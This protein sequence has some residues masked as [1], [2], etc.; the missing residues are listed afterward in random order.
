MIKIL[1]YTQNP[2]TYMGKIAGI[3]YNSDTE[4]QD[5]NYKRGLKNIEHNHGRVFEYVDVTL[6]IS[7]YSARAI[8]ELYTHIVGTSRLQES[9]RYVTYDINNFSYHVPD[10]IYNNNI[11]FEKYSQ[12]MRNILDTY[13]E[14]LELGVSKEDVANILPLGQTSKVILKINYRAL[15]HLAEVRLCERAYEEIRTMVLEIIEEISKLD[16]EWKELTSYMKPKCK[17]CTEKENC[18]KNK[19]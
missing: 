19:R 18:P 2:I 4:S 12:C 10:S 15:L 16:N 7:G 1:N 8:R 9:T 3:C 14:L 6:E 17:I 11:A 13:Q 5:K